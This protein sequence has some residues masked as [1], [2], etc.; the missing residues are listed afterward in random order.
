M[1][2]YRPLPGYMVKYYDSET[3]CRK[4]KF[5]FSRG[6]IPANADS[7]VSSYVACGQCIGCRLA[8]SREWAIRC[9]HE[10]KCWHENCFI[11]LTYDDLHYPEDGSLCYRDF[12]LFMKRLRK[13][14]KGYDCIVND[15]GYLEYPIRFFCCGEY[16]E[17]LNRPHF[18]ACIFN[19]NFE[20]KRLWSVRDGVRL[21][22]SPLLEQLWD[23][24]YSTIGDVTFE[25]A[26]YVARYV[27]KK[28]TGDMA[29]EHYVNQDTGVMRTPEF[30]KMSN[31]PGIGRDWIDQYMDDVYPNDFVVH[32]NVK[33][34]PPRYY[35]KV[36]DIYNSDMLKELKVRR[37][38]RARF[39]KDNTPDRLYAREQVQLARCRKLKR[40]FESETKGI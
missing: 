24:G 27:M 33:M 8:R 21:Y 40:G 5:V 10:A 28:I 9:V 38:A 22:R 25:S 32:S 1:T 37:E 20:D 39:C 17:Q 16:G 15:N 35:D 26:A 30:V 29:D 2:C 36:Y 7:V 14:C 34:R 13:R 18:H 31:R 6:S 4:T 12:Q 19:F 11:T 23:K 3:G